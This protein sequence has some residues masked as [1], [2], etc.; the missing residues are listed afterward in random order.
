MRT[1][2]RPGGNEKAQAEAVV[3]AE[4]L[5]LVGLRQ[6]GHDSAMMN[7]LCVPALEGAASL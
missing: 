2:F 1:A 7:I 3:A 6:F 5:L 4:A